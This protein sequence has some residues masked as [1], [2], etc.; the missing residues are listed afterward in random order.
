[1]KKVK[2]PSKAPQP[3]HEA[4]LYA[5]ALELMQTQMQP[6]PAER[7]ARRLVA[8]VSRRGYTVLVYGALLPAIREGDRTSCRRASALLDR[9]HLPPEIHELGDEL[10]QRC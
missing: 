4:E 2:G 10:F 3:A 5:L 7:S 8:D 6:V 9:L 1:M